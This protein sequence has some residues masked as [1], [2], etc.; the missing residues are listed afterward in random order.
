LRY[1]PEARRPRTLRFRWCATRS[2]C[3][4]GGWPG[5]RSTGQTGRCWLGSLG[6]SPGRSGAGCS[7]NRR[8]CCDGI[9][10]WSGAGGPP[11]AGEA[12]Q[13][14]RPNS[15]T[16]CCGWPGR[17][18]RGA[19]AASRESCAGSGTRLGPAPRGPS[20]NAP[21][22]L[23]HQHRRPCH[24]GSPFGLR[25]TVCWPWT[26]FTVDTVLLKRLYV[27]VV[28]EVATG[29]VHVLGVTPH[30]V[31]AWSPAG[32][33]PAHRPRRARHPLPVPDPRSGYEVHRRV[34]RGLRRRGHQGAHHAGA[35]AAGQC[36]RRA[37]G[38]HGSA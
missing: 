24:G 37:V 2:R 27:L 1:W 31:G 22:L 28:I 16:W 26:F 7:C 19:I 13:A 21:A 38:G 4:A 30:P 14:C 12:V 15:A 11:Q 34:R 3:C 9:G 8:R 29:R 20:F 18:P 32:P 5:R 35:G 10:T 25:P 17:T 36:L 6:C 23:R 33:E